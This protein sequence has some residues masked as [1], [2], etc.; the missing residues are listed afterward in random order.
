M[1]DRE[2]EELE[3]LEPFSDLYCCQC[4]IATGWWEAAKERFIGTKRKPSD[5]V[6][7]SSSKLSIEDIEQ[8]KT[9]VI[10]SKGKKESISEQLM[11]LDTCI[12][13]QPTP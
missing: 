2:A 5:S 1:S 7:N 9:M 13:N 3:R 8:I 12:S 4:D 10:E 11:H 6:S